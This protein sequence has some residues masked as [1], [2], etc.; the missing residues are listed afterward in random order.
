MIKHIL[1]KNI[2]LIDELSIEFYDGFNVLTGETGAGKSIIIDSVNLALGERADRDLIKSGK[3]HARVEVLFSLSNAAKV[4]DILTGYGI[5]PEP[6]ETLLLTRELTVQG[7]NVC[8]INGRTV[9]LSML[10]EITRHLVDIH[11][12]H[13]H[14]YLLNPESHIEFLDKY[15]GPVLDEPKHQLANTYNKWLNVRKEIS[16]IEGVNRDGVR[17]KDILLYQINEIKEARLQPGEEE[18]LRKERTLMLHAEKIMHAANESYALLYTGKQ[19]SSSVSDKLAEAL[20]LIKAVENIDDSLDS[21][22]DQLENLQYTLEDVVIRLR[23]FKESFEYDPYRLEEIEERLQLIHNLKRKYGSSIE[24][25]LDFK[26]ELESELSLIENSEERL[27]ILKSQSDDL[28][29]D[30]VKSCIVVSDIRKQKAMELEKELV[31]HLCDLNMD[32]TRFKVSIQTP[33]ATDIDSMFSSVTENGFD[34]VEFL[35]SPNPGEPLRPLAKIISGGE[36]S[37]VMLAFKTLLADIDEIPTM[38]FDE[39]DVGVSGRTA[40]KV[41]EKIGTISKVHQ[42]ICVTHLPQIA[43]M[44]D[45]H[46][47][48]EKTTK[49]NQT[50]TLVSILDTHG[51]QKE[52]A[53]MI[54]GTEITQLSL[55]HAGELINNAEIFKSK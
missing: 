26:A 7:K 27:A 31:D 54:G 24:E 34:K 40:Q 36:M 41:A 8:R 39:I 49:N 47:L 2:A 12:Q 55:E 6:D 29:S 19:G 13:Q 3:D 48:I 15:C 18:E 35:I 42:V 20:S 5:D 44:A 52:I 9:T 4:Y 50:N 51:R 46:Y 38:I 22:A 25:I 37:R 1:I 30:L 16:R 33:D 32:K 17:R 21:I 28:F 45:Y 14:Q 10:R 11:G 23:D 53:R 43:S